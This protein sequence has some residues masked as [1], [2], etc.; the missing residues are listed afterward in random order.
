MG[1]GEDRG[2]QP[3]SPRGSGEDRAGADGASPANAHNRF[4]IGCCDGEPKVVALPPGP[5][6]DPRGG[7]GGECQERAEDEKEVICPL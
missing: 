3:R 7:P 5:G 1:P 6:P 4:H 2:R